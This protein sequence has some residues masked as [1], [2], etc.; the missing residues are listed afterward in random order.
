MGGARMP[1]PAAR[2]GGAAAWN[3]G[4]DGFFSDGV[5]E[6]SSA[7]SR[8][9]RPAQRGGGAHRSGRT[10]TK[11]QSRVQHTDTAERRATEER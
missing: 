2:K 6:Q 10:H 5:T 9:R 3:S 7:H 4:S 11:Q 8:R 1:R